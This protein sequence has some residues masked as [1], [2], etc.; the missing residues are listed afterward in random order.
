MVLRQNN[1]E[2]GLFCGKQ[3][4]QVEKNEGNIFGG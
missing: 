1:E 3:D 2:L 4:G